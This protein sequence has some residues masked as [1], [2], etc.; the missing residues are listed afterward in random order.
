MFFDGTSLRYVLAQV[1][2]N[3]IVH[4]LT[5]RGNPTSLDL[6]GLFLI[7]RMVLKQR[8]VPLQRRLQ[9]DFLV[10]Q[11]FSRRHS[12]MLPIH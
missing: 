12:S 7:L 11:F 5:N 2:E 6:L 8:L 1:K 4:G 10:S 3:L 9:L